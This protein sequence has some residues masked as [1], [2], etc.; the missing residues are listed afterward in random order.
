MHL[1]EPKCITGNRCG[2]APKHGILVDQ[3]FSGE[4]PC[5]KEQWAERGRSC[6][7]R[8]P[9]M[10][11]HP[12]LP[13]FLLAPA[14]PSR[15]T[16]G[17]LCDPIP[18]SNKGPLPLGRSG[19]TEVPVSSIGPVISSK[20]L[21]LGYTSGQGLVTSGLTP[22]QCE[23]IFLLSHEVQ[24]LCRELALDFIGLSHQEA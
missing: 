21:Q 9:T 23:E 18:G 3:G 1:T 6:E 13:P 11:E 24:T 5:P 17:L 4:R 14:A 20:M 19:D 8:H 16:T 2:M 10:P 7:C 15:P 22:A 12:Q